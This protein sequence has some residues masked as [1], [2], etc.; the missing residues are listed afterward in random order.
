MVGAVALLPVLAACSTGGQTSPTDDG[1]DGTKPVNIAF[2]GY[3][4]GDFPEAVA[5]GAEDVVSADGGTVTSFDAHFDPQEQ[6]SQCQDAITSGRFQAIILVPVDPATGVPCAAAAAAAGIPVATMETAVGT[7][8]YAL[9]P[10][11][12][13][14][15][16][17]AVTPLESQ[18]SVDVELIKEACA[19][20]SPC[21][22]IAEI[23][24]PT[25]RWTNDLI[26]GIETALGSDAS[27]VQKV[28]S[29]YDPGQIAKALPDALN[30]HP[31]AQVFF[32]VSDQSALAA[33]P[34]IAQAGKTEQVKIIGLGG[35][36]QATEAVADG[37]LFGT[38]ATWPLQTG[39][40]LAEAL[41]ESVSGSEITQASVDLLKI[42]TPVLITGET[43]GEFK[44]EWG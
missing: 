40:L 12:D 33:I 10:Q 21:E 6:I 8:P 22:I 2:L 11:V 27:V 42:D 20:A 17:V 29:Q 14:V 13:G 26:N 35:S 15:V 31:D 7:D 3:I 44:P 25:D 38:T 1:S 28:V 23:S 43:V 4:G 19:G 37:T 41:I 30:A 39:K 18:V 34:V 24:S 36:G 32:A 9:E 5:Q 16:A